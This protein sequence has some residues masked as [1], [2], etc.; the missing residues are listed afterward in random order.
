MSRLKDKTAIVTGAARGIGAGIARRFVAE[1]ARVLLADIEPKGLEA[2]AGELAQP[3]VRTDVT[4]RADIEAMVE[5]AMDEFG[6]IDILVNNAGVNIAG[7]FLTLPEETF[8]RVLATNLKSAFLASQLAGKHMASRRSGV[9]INMSSVNSNLAIPNQLP[10]AVSKGGLKQ[11]TNASALALAPY[12]IRVVAIGPGTIMTDLARTT[13]T[14]PSV[15]EKVMARTPLGRVGEIEE[16][17]AL[18]VF[19]ASDE[20]GYITGHT[21]FMDGGRMGLNLTMPPAN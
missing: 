8:D 10:Y 21:V 11:L 3:F 18:T 9:I 17:A 1:G 5:R 4:K 7:D 15:L 20:A 2:V 16:V 6:R 19:L 13:L 12:G 14:D